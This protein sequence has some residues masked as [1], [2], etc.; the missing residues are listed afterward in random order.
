[1]IPKEFKLK[2]FSDDV[3]VWKNTNIGLQSLSEDQ[4]REEIINAIAKCARE[5]QPIQAPMSSYL[6]ETTAGE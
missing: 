3:Y 2:D 5:E 6:L 4:W 1:M